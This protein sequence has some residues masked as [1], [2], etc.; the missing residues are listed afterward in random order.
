MWL[1]STFLDKD[2]YQAH[3]ISR[4]NKRGSGLLLISKSCYKQEL[5]KE[6]DQ[7]TFEGATWKL[8][9][10]NV[11]VTVM[12]IYHPPQVARLP[13]SMFI[14]QLSD[15]LME[16]LAQH[17]N[18]IVVGDFNIYINDHN[19]VDAGLLLETLSALGLDQKVSD[20]THNKGNT[21]DLI[22]VEDTSNSNVQKVETLEFISDHRPV[23]CILNIQKP[24]LP[25][26]KKEYHKLTLKATN[27]IPN[28]YDA[29][30]LYNE[31]DANEMVCKV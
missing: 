20:A 8:K 2:P 28:Q 7:S 22:F 14:D 27:D 6:A 16:I 5:I 19:D 25:R 24:S 9:I 18:N 23:A 4:T 13:N 1:K 3:P 31:V 29:Q 11:S 26:C 15:Y 10:G 21:I 17:S 30:V 12:G